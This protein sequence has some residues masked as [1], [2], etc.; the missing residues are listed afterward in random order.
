MSALG[1]IPHLLFPHYIHLGNLNLV[2]EQKINTIPSIQHR[3]FDLIL[4]FIITPCPSPPFQSSSIKPDGINPTTTCK[5]TPLA[6]GDLRI[7][8]NMSNYETRI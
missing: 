7:L 2:T 4:I 3:S 8:D 6:A 5:E 1:I